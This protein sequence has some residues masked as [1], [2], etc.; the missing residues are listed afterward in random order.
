MVVSCNLPPLPPSPPSRLFQSFELLLFPFVALLVVIVSIQLMMMMMMLLLLCPQC[1]EVRL[2]R[3]RHCLT[4]SP[5]CYHLL[6]LLLLEYC[7]LVLMKLLPKSRNCIENVFVK[8]FGDG[9]CVHCDDDGGGDE[10]ESCACVQVS[11]VRL[12]SLT[13]TTMRRTLLLFVS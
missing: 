2:R 4:L 7:S 12:V 6:L 8:R 3:P 10:R 1:S 11:K 5:P 9:C 13:M